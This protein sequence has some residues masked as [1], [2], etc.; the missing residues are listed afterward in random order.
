MAPRLSLVIPVYNRP[1]EIADLLQSLTSQTDSDF[2]VII[3]EDGSTLPC[4][5]EVQSYEDLLSIRYLV[6]PN[7]GP[8]KAR[9]IGV[10]AAGGAYII[11]LD[12]D[13][14]LP[15]GYIRSV[16]AAI[17][18]TGADAFGGPDTAAEDFSDIQKAINYSMTSFFT[19]GGIR[20]GKKK[21]DRFYPRSFNL[22]CR[23]SV[24]T[25]L[26]GF[27]E[28][29]RFGED[30]DFSLRLF[31]QGYKVCLFD[32]ASVYHKR[33]VDFKKFFKQVFNSG[34][35]RI[36]IEARHSGSMRLVHLLPSLFSIGLIVLL[37]LS[38]FFPWVLLPL[39]L[40]VL[41]IFVDSLL[42]NHSLSVACLSVP[43]A[44]VQLIGYGTGLLRAWWSKNIQRK[45]EFTA[46][47]KSFYD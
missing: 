18:R 46:F 12:S 29:M 17:L 1:Q 41:M 26:N 40:Y 9:N 15:S 25:K 28:D 3:V 4:K 42:K 44:F 22:G 5:A 20:G 38:F 36:H 10:K 21:L 14:V 2:E 37:I 24:F 39:L 35:A 43:A 31:E 34:M 8:S 47:D 33:R 32:E 30:I 23:R 19:T 13:V 27:S 6:T 11:I 7:G 45:S 16:R